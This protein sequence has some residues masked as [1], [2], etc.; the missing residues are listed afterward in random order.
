[1]TWVLAMGAFFIIG[2][3]VTHEELKNPI[4]LRKEKP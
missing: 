1:V 3:A 4:Q 2:G